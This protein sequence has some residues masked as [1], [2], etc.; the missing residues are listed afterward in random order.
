M[1]RNCALKL[2]MFP[3]VFRQLF[4]GE[5]WTYTYLLADTETGEAVLVDPVNNH[6]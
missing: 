2:P 1:H 3:K 4:E 5:S 6:L